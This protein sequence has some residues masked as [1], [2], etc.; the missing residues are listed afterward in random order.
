VNP[1]S[2]KRRLLER[3]CCTIIPQNAFAKEIEDGAYV[4]RRI[5]AP[6]LPVTL[7]LLSQ[8][9][10]QET[11]LDTILSAVSMGIKKAGVSSYL[12]QV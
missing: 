4:A 5:V 7:F 8:A 10:I 9:Q 2:A 1:L 3:G 6:R 11:R 12:P